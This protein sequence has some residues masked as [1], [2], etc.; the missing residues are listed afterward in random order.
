MSDPEKMLPG[1]RCPKMSRFVTPRKDVIR[2]A[3]GALAG[4][5]VA[6]APLAAAVAADTAVAFVGHSGTPSTA[7]ALAAEYLRRG[8]A[9]RALAVVLL[10]SLLAAGIGFRP[11]PQPPAPPADA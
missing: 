10:I 7:A 5:V 9:R 6:A 4:P 3:R 1:P 2:L 8:T 11:T